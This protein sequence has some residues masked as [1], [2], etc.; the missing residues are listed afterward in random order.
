MRTPLGLGAGPSWNMNYQDP[1]IPDVH[2]FHLSHFRQIKWKIN[3]VSLLNKLMVL[4]AAGSVSHWIPIPDVFLG[5]LGSA[6]AGLWHR[7]SERSHRWRG[8][9]SGAF[10]KRFG[11]GTGGGRSSAHRLSAASREKIKWIQLA[12]IDLDGSLLIYSSWGAGPAAAG[13]GV[14]Q[15]LVLRN[16]GHGS[17]LC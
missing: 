2:S 9:Y 11:V 15:F 7:H 12:R 17:Q 6:P 13:V 3:P 1:F 8:F 5:Q 4:G 10:G 14:T 16:L